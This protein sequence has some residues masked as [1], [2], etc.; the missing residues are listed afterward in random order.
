M[1][2]IILCGGQ[3]TRLREETEYKPKP[4][5]MI[6]NKPILWHIM[7][8]YAHFGFKEFILCLGYKKEVIQDYFGKPQE[9]WEVSLV[10]TGLHTKKGTRI[11]MV[12]PYIQEEDFML[13]YGDGLCN[14]NIRDLV[15]FHHS[16]TKTVTFTGVQPTSRYAT[17]DF[18]KEGEIINWHEKKKLESYVNG[19]FFVMK[20]KVFEFLNNDCEFEEEPMKKLAQSQE[21][22]MY[23]H[24]GFW[25]CMDTYRDS[26]FLNGLWN[27]KKSLW[28]VWGS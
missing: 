13:T 24:N 19:G 11:K 28:Q 3:G 6:G 16:H 27:Q 21:V 5:V 8:T 18:D 23:R 15:S 4:M 22:K 20:K 17:V 25:H 2:V 14:V 26:L 9:D 12:E 10:D 1:K 7:K